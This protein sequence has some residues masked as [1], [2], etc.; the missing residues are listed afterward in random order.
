MTGWGI[1]AYSI[2][3]VGIVLMLLL[4]SDAN[5]LMYIAAKV[6]SAPITIGSLR[7]NVATIATAFCACLTVLTYSGVQRSMSKYVVNSNQPQILP[8]DYDKMKMFYDERNFWMSLLGLI[9]WSAAWRLESLYLKRTAPAG[10]AVQRLG[11][12]S[13]GMRGVWLTVGCGV[14]LLADLPLCRANYKMQLANYVTPG[15]EVLLPQAKECEGV[16]LSQAQGTCQ[17]FCQEVQALSEERQ[18]CVLFARRWHL[19]GRWAAQLF[20]RCHPLLPTALLPLGHR[21]EIFCGS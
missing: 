11:P 21:T 1:L 16:M 14:L 2:V 5:I 13:L 10:G 19:L 17:N 15:K 3:P 12:R 18:N 20:F 6:L 7:L 4:L 9:T 8:R